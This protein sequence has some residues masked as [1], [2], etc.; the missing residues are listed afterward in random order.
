MIRTEGRRVA[1][2]F[3]AAL[4]YRTFAEL[5]DAPTGEILSRHADA[6]APFIGIPEADRLFYPRTGSYAACDPFEAA[7]EGG[8]DGRE[9]MIGFT[10]FEMGLWLL[11]DTAFDTRSPEWAAAEQ[12]QY[13]PA[14]A[15]Q[16]MPDLY[17]R[18]LPE[19]SDGRRAMHMIG[20][21]I[22]AMPSLFLADLLSRNGSRSS[23][24]ASIGRSTSALGR[25]MRRTCRSFS[26]RSPPSRV[27]G[28]WDGPKRRQRPNGAKRCPDFRKA[29]HSFAA[30]GQPDIA[31][32]PGSPMTPQSE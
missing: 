28:S 15:R 32:N 16:A 11:W 22:F 12:V 1:A 3:F 29:I 2:E 5:C 19:E 6:L 31:G 9:V 4:G 18:W 21:A 20:D 13:V 27:S 25:S 17:R 23:C 7:A 10:A 8:A 26:A 24:T 30:T 14:R